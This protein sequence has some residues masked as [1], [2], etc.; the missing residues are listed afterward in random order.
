M[1][2]FLVLL[3]VLALVISSFAGCAKSGDAVSTDA[4]SL[5]IGLVGPWTGAS[6]QNG[7]SMKRG[8]EL[9]VQDINAAGGAK[10]YQ[11][12][13]VAYDDQS[14]PEESVNAVTKLVSQDNVLAIVGAFNSACTLADMEVTN[15]EKVPQITPISMS[16][17]VNK[18]D[19]FMFRNTLGATQAG[20]VFD[21][22]AGPGK[23]VLTD[24]TN[25]NKVAILWE[26]DDWG[27]GMSDAVM[28][29]AE[30]LG[31]TDKF[32]ANV[33]Y[34]PGT[35]DFY[36]ILTPLLEKNPDMIYCVSLATEAIQ[37]VKQ[38][39]ELGYKGLF[40]GEGGFNAQE[41]D[42]S[43]GELAYGALFSTQ[44]HSSFQFPLSKQFYASFKAAYPDSEPDMFSAISYEAVYIVKDSIE[45]A[46]DTPEDISTWRIALRDAMAQ[47]K[48]LAG[49]CGPVTFDNVGQS[50]GLIYVLQ[51]T[52]DGPV[53]VL[54][55]DVA[56]GEIRRDLLPKK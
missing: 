6:A 33:P 36:P 13:L 18:N 51:K 7:V 54:P 42:T 2:K 15:R 3:L 48:D 27:K 23:M 19:D 39:R 22:L 35:T 49:V 37:I 10:G 41:F 25:S 16:D 5:K 26:N 20:E 32:V 55:K 1:K 12:E 44:W 11:L 8:V 45:R 14:I 56:G 53:I 4:K 47:T 34:N 31:Q 46:T 40:L 38:A 43:L 24:G 28:L 9:A 50:K 30:K 21:A 29:T 17:D 52:A